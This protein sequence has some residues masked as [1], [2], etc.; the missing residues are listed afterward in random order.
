MNALFNTEGKQ[1]IN[2]FCELF[3]SF[4]EGVDAMPRAAPTPCRH[5]GCGAVLT[6][7]GY[8]DTHRT[9]VHRDYGRARRGFDTERGF[10]QSAVWRG[11][12]SAF[13]REHPLCAHCTARG[14]VVAAVVADHAVPLKD[15]GARLDWSNLSPLCISHHNAKTASETA[16]RSRGS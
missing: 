9:G 1:K 5:P 11:V 15:G 13:L 10:Y 6:T 4:L 8:C 12:R 16:R 14:R 7:P 2:N 3:Q